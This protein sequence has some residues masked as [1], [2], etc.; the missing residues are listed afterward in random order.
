LRPARTTTSRRQCA[1][2]DAPLTT[3]T[4]VR[5]H[6][7]GDCHQESPVRQSPAWRNRAGTHVEVSRSAL[8]TVGGLGLYYPEADWWLGR[9][10]QRRL[11]SGG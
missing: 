7:A 8:Q 5:R 4:L 6:R 11:V 10:S 1:S 3:Q 2:D 9:V